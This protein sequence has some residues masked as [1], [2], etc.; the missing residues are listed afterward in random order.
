MQLEVNGQTY[1]V[2][3]E[4]DEGHWHVVA[5]TITGLREIPV[6]E[7]IVDYRPIRVVME[8]TDEEQEIIN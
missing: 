4:S 1:F 3:F 6:V 5:P 8:P 2:N 7:D